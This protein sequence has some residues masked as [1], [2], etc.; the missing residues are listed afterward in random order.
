MYLFTGDWDVIERQICDGSYETMREKRSR[1]PETF[2][3]ID[4]ENPVVLSFLAEAGLT[5]LCRTQAWLR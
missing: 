5:N 4:L 2:R 3:F 1:D